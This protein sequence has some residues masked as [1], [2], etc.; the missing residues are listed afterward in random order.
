MPTGSR[1]PS[2]PDEGQQIRVDH[3]CVGG[4]AK[5]PKFVT[6]MRAQI[7]HVFASR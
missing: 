6:A 4:Q 7:A 1:E 3:V 2:A 5:T